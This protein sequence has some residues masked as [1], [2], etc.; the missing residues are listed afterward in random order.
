MRRM[1]IA[2]ERPL[3]TLVPM[4]GSRGRTPQAACFGLVE[5]TNINV[6]FLKMSI[7]L[8][9]GRGSVAEAVNGGILYLLY[10]TVRVLMLPCL[11]LLYAHDAVYAHEATWT[12][13]ARTALQLLRASTCVPRCKPTRCRGFPC[14]R[15]TLLPHALA[16]RPAA[17]RRPVCTLFIWGLSCMWFTTIHRGMMKVLRGVDVLEGEEG[18]LQEMHLA[19]DEAPPPAA[20]QKRP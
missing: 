11:V 18:S 16:A 12:A 2:V 4:F 15:P 7:I 1:A 19:G 6:A 17:T 14:A 3:T 5:V 9:V 13:D 20:K 10:L 8:N